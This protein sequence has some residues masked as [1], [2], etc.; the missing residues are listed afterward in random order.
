[1]EDEILDEPL[2]EGKSKISFFN[3]SKSKPDGIRTKV[4]GVSRMMLCFFVLLFAYM[5]LNILLES[6]KFQNIGIDLGIILL[7]FIM[8]GAIM[9]NVVQAFREIRL[10]NPIY[11][12]NRLRIF[13]V[14]FNLIIFAGI[15]YW[16]IQ[17]FMR[18]ANPIDNFPF[19][20]YGFLILY[21]MLS[22]DIKHLRI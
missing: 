20:I 13:S 7:T 18:G 21:A 3:R 15:I 2:E 19:Y 11:I 5:K 12:K 22:Q 1:M 6:F 4:T 16:T 8:I 14:L 10:A 17:L 9:F